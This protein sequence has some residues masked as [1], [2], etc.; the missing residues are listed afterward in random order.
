MNRIVL[1][2]LLILSSTCV[3]AQESVEKTDSTITR[4]V[5]PEKEL[6]LWYGSDD[7]RV[8]RF[9]ILPNYTL[10]YNNELSTFRLLSNA[11][12]LVKDEERLLAIKLI[13]P[14]RV[15]VGNDQ[16]WALGP[17]T[18]WFTVLTDST[19]IAG[20]VLF[21][22]LNGVPGYL[23]I[24]IKNDKLLIDQKHF[25]LDC[26]TDAIDSNNM[27]L[28]SQY[29]DYKGLQLYSSLFV[30]APTPKNKFVV[31]KSVYLKTAQK[32]LYPCYVREDNLEEPAE[33]RQLIPFQ[34]IA[35]N[36]RLLIYDP[37][38]ERLRVVTTD[39]ANPVLLDVAEALPGNVPKGRKFGREFMVDRVTKQLYY[40][41]LADSNGS[42]D[43]LVMGVDLKADKITFDPVLRSGMNDYFSRY[44]NNRKLFFYDSKK[45]YIYVTN[46]D[47]P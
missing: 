38:A 3:R 10:L 7:F 2:I 30:L 44:V 11:E 21:S 1:L 9:V 6:K 39:I 4:I 46:A 15:N 23:L 28:L 25:D 34:L 47:L 29:V 32:P 12:N 43:Q 37:E 24:T 19:V 13:K 18:T 27:Q 20:T 26:K 35:T 41:T 40:K 5:Y 45:G 33:K 36:D 42:V 14:Y 16:K 22:G 17:T 8:D 31:K